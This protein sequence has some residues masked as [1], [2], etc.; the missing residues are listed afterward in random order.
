MMPKTEGGPAYPVVTGT[1]VDEITYLTCEKA[2]LSKLEAFAMAAMQGDWASP[3][4]PWPLTQE[5]QLTRARLYY[6]MAR[7]MIEAGEEAT[8]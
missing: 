5:W 3:T 4:S 7:A 2:C 8:G 1:R 6:E